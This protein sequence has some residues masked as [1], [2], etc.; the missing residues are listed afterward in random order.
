VVPGLIPKRQVTLLYGD[1]G[2]GKSLVTLQL[3]M[4]MAAG[5]SWM[6]Q[7]VASGSVLYWTAED[8]EDELQRR[9]ADAAQV[10]GIEAHQLSRLSLRSLT[11]CD[12]ELARA[13]GSDVVPTALFRELSEAVSVLKPT[14]VV[15]DTL[16]EHFAV[17]EINR[18]HAVRAVRLLR[19]IASANGCA[20]LVLAH[21]SLGS[22]QTGRGASG[23]TGWSNAVRSRL[24]LTRI[25]D[26]NGTE[27]DPD[28][29]TLRVMKSNHAAAGTEFNIR[30]RDGAFVPDIKTPDAIAA[31][32]ASAE[33][34]FMRLLREYQREG[35]RVRETTGV[36]YAPTEFVRSGRS[37]GH[38]RDDLHGAMQRLFRRGLIRVEEYGPPSKLRRHIVEVTS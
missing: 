25:I 5:R 23:S 8:D 17:D 15:L 37:E 33:D 4:A 35:R 13:D 19:R 26:K 21:P 14:L 1:G 11:D 32:A 12:P 29:R 24:W 18:S 3:G 34:V 16:A 6:G 30:F 20:F 38:S 10:D 2:V 36:G 28:A 22:L 27:P 31:S 7:P 9:L